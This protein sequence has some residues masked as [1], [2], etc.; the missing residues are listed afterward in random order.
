MKLLITV[1]LLALVCFASACSS[2]NSA[3]KKCAR[4]FTNY[5]VSDPCEITVEEDKSGA[6]SVEYNS[7]RFASCCDV[8]NNNH[9]NCNF[10][11]A[12]G[13][14]D[15]VWVNIGEHCPEGYD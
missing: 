1:M 7:S 10:H 4:F 14:Y 13:N 15:N 2:N 11:S 3:I 8:V 5:N 9:A 6:L 12:K